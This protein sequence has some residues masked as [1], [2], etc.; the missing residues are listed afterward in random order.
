L[1][2]LIFTCVTACAADSL[3]V[4]S[5]DS[6]LL[7]VPLFHVNAWGIPYSAAMTGAKLV[8]PG[9]HLDGKSICELL[10]NEKVSQRPFVHLIATRLSNTA[11]VC[12]MNR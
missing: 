3:A 10:R 9:P 1:L 12:Q 4:A 2:N 7:I 8:L 5:N 6:I 11:T